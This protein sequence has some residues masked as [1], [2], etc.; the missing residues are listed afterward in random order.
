MTASLVGDTVDKPAA[1][2]VDL[3]DI[4]PRMVISVDGFG[5]PDGAA[6]RDALMTLVPLAWAV[7][8]SLKR[9][10][11]AADHHVAHLE[12]LWWVE[13]DAVPAWS[14]E[15]AL[16]CWRALVGESTDVP[17]D[18]LEQVVRDVPAAKSLPAA[19]LVELH[20][21]DEGLCVQTLHVGPYAQ[22]PTTIAVMGEFMAAHDLVPNGHHHEIYLSDP[23]RCD[24][25]RLQT[26]LRQP[27]RRG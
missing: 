10:S 8:A 17:L 27:V 20:K 25:A 22:E 12:A 15:K 9:R 26:V 19:R 11:E 18:V 3:V 7:H 4:A 23:R 5:A 13:G 14:D 6:F 24:P 16:W 1:G 21:F 2:R